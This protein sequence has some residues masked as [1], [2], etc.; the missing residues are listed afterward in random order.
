MNRF[1]KILCVISGSETNPVALA[2]AVSL[3]EN[4]QA[5][6]HVISVM[7][8]VSIG[9]GMPEGGPISKELNSLVVKTRTQ[10]LNAVVD[11]HC[12]GQKPS[13]RVLV[14]VE[15]IEIIREVLRRG[16]DLVIKAA[17]ELDWMEHLLGS[18]DMHLLRKCPC[19]VWLIKPGDSKPYRRVL[20]AIDF[21]D[22]YPQAERRPRRA[23]NQQ[24]IEMASSIALSEFAELHIAHAWE[25]VGES[26]LRN[27]MQ[28]REIDV[29]AYVANVRKRREAGLNELA[30]SVTA[31]LGPEVV[32][33]LRPESHLLEGRARR[34]I[35]ILAEK[36]DVDL[37]VMGTVGRTGI[38]GFFAG[39][40]AE[41]I[42][43]Q[44]DCSVLAIK[45]IGFQTPVDLP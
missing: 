17:E 2:R 15:F 13:T 16:Y 6:L 36:L 20:A 35:P 34:E 40:T 44:I 18:E 45:P 30:Q 28:M 8:P 14:G 10:A 25:A 27:A 43:T 12:A 32:D 41:S 22:L 26:T 29:E 38:P 39:N 33:Y 9:M 4:N 21:T 37:I 1:K 5:E 24:I 42:L 3:A 11:S 7:A 19:P 23:L 31:D